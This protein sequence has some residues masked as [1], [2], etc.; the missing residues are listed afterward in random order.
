MVRSILLLIFAVFLVVPLVDASTVTNDEVKAL[1]EARR[2]RDARLKIQDATNRD[3]FLKTAEGKGYYCGALCFS[4]PADL[5]KKDITNALAHGESAIRALKTEDPALQKWV[6]SAKTT[7]ETLLKQ[8]D[9]ESRAEHV[10]EYSGKMMQGCQADP[11]GVFLQRGD[12]PGFTWT[13]IPPAISETAHETTPGEQMLQAAVRDHAADGSRVAVCSPFISVSSS[14]SNA[15][16]LCKRARAFYDYFTTEYRTQEP[17]AWITIHHYATKNQ[18]A[19]HIRKQKGPACPDVLGYYDWRRQT[20]ALLAQP[21][22][23]GTLDH[24]L[25]HA[26][27]FWDYPSAPLWLEEGMAALYEN[28]DKNF[29]G[30]ANPWREQVMRRLGNPKV[31]PVYFERVLKMSV[32]DFEREVA[33]ATI[34]RAF[35]LQIQ[36]CG[37]LAKLY[38]R[39]RDS[40]QN[41]PLPRGPNPETPEPAET[42]AAWI[43]TVREAYCGSQ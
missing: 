3:D 42:V 4:D 27:I 25:T 12:R 26:F 23:A 11:S 20:V 30:L 7:C 5:S 28:T 39:V 32:F 29:V 15:D 10:R 22:M 38:F 33:P 43:R 36:R 8:V 31:D 16:F 1:L 14:Q 34:A 9:R 2:C 18:M 19:A 24:E 13:A 40:D 6:Q 21:G 35:I 37:N 17:R 41:L